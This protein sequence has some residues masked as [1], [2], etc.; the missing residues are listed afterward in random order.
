MNFSGVDNISNNGELREHQFPRV[1]DV[2]FSSLPIVHLNE[3]TVKGYQ[4]LLGQEVISKCVTGRV[5]SGS[6]PQ[7]SF[8]NDANGELMLSTLD[9]AFAQR[10]YFTKHWLT[11]DVDAALEVGFT[12]FI[13]IYILGD[14]E[15]RK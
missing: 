10:K 4:G 14:V 2:A 1:S 13:D 8:C 3:Q 11:E 7:P 5:F 6:C 15:T 12:K 9:N